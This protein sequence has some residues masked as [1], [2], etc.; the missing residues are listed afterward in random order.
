M[1]GLQGCILFPLEMPR[2]C[3]AEERM[4]GQQGCMLFPLEMPAMCHD[5]AVH[6]MLKDAEK[7]TAEREG[8][9]LRISE[10]P[11]GI[12]RAGQFVSDCILTGILYLLW[13]GLFN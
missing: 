6:G 1:L 7:I 8:L 12:K 5:L 4:L 2:S 11:I 13:A 10:G 3:L 9:M